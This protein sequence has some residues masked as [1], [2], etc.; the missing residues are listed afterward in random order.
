VT[1]SCGLSK[2]CSHG[3]ISAWKLV[4]SRWV[5]KSAWVQMLRHSDIDP[6]DTGTV[7]NH[8][9][10]EALR[11]GRLP[12]RSAVK[13][14]GVGIGWLLV[15]STAGCSSSPAGFPSGSGVATITW[16]RVAT[17]SSVQSPPQPF[18]GAIAGISVSGRSVTPVPKADQNPGGG[19]TIPSH[20]VLA[21]WTGT[22]QGTEFQMTV[23]VGSLSI[24]DLSSFKV[25][26]SGK[27]GSQSVQGTATS[28]SSQGGRLTF[29]G[30]VGHHH[31][32]GSVKEPVEHSGSGTATATFT[33]T[34]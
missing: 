34:G 11:S 12:Q 32:V 30:T 17:T 26:I 1:N 24:S 16:H 31:V 4:R 22:F 19:I 5:L 8:Q 21:R 23:S 28:S 25:D 15:V 13:M 6:S 3:L 10:T 27:F 14:V 18:S 33:V 2:A 9:S 29:Q 20:L 7:R